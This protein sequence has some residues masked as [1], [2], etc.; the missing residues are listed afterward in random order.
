[1]G[2]DESFKILVLK[3]KKFF[4]K[5]RKT[6]TKFYPQEKYNGGQGLWKGEAKKLSRPTAPAQS[7][8]SEGGAEIHREEVRM[9]TTHTHTL[10]SSMQGQHNAP[11]TA[12]EGD[13]ER[14]PI[15]VKSR[16]LALHACFASLQSSKLGKVTSSFWTSISSPLKS[17]S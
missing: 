4:K 17:K 14:N 2:F 15:G 8:S 1:M 6:V 11:Q 3:V 12:D 16:K 10:H 9:C 7:E 5:S 13:K